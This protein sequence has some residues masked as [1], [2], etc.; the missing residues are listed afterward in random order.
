MWL[1]IFVS[2]SSS[3]INQSGNWTYHIPMRIWLN[4]TK[5][6]SILC[7]F[8]EIKV[9]ESLCGTLGSKLVFTRSGRIR[10][11]IHSRELICDVAY[12]IFGIESKFNITS[13]LKYICRILLILLKSYFYLF[14]C[15]IEKRRFNITK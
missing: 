6:G 2:S 13:Q 1:L 7:D 9:T 14:L 12:C 5:S 8:V 3:Q 15:H 4:S 10:Y 11:W